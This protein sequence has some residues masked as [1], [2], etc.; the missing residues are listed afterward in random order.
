MLSP[1][2]VNFLQDGIQRSFVVLQARYERKGVSSF[3]VVA[4]PDKSTM[5]SGDIQH[6]REDIRAHVWRTARENN[7]FLIG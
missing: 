2:S 5:L 3:S 6:G 4:R 1:M 7:P